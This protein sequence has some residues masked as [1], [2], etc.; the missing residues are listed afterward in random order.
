MGFKFLLPCVCILWGGSSYCE[1]WDDGYQQAC[2]DHMC[3]K[4]TPLCE[5]SEIG[6]T[7]YKSGFGNGYAQALK[8]CNDAK[9]N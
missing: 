4:P 9:E 7:T 2:A 1:G 6:A 3:V 5:P 8:D